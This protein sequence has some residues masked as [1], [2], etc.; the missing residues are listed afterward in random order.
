MF[1]LV[2]GL[3]AFAAA[4]IR[5]QE[6][7]PAGWLLLAVLVVVVVVRDTVAPIARWR[8]T[9]FVVTNHRVLV[10][11][12]VFA[13]G[14]IDVPMGGWTRCAPGGRRSS[15][16]WDAARC[17]SSGRGG[18][19]AVREMPHVERVQA[20]LHREIGREIDRRREE[21]GAA[22]VPERSAS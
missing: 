13:R 22:A 5:R 15:A 3:G 17:S 2:V 21:R 10:R 11:E 20:L 16:W 6:W 12:G 1:L 4:V 7:A 18:A 19:D 14:G 9:H 8:T